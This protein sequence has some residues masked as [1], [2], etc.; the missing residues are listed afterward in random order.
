MDLYGQEPETKLLAGFLG[1]LDE[2]VVLDV[3]AEQGSFAQAM[4]DAGARHVHVVE[5][6]PQNLAALRD[7]FGTNA[8]VTVH[9]VAAGR[10]DG[11]LVLHVSVGPDGSPVPYGH[12]ILERPATTEIAWGDPIR[13]Q[14]RSIGSLV[15]DGL[16]PERVGIVKIDTEGNDLA[17]V[18]GLGDIVCD[19][20]V[21]EHWD[22]LPL[23]LGPCPWTLDEV[24]GAMRARGFEH[25]AFI[26]HRGEL[27]LLEWDVAELSAGEMGNLVFIHERAVARLLPSAIACA[28][29]LALRAYDVTRMYAQAA[30]ERLELIQ[31]LDAELRAR[32]AQA[33]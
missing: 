27:V 19:V 29:A 22:D 17:V 21:L 20:V 32:E 8:A 33:R 4:L 24:A 13:V 28:S 11:E 9:P 10:E 6:E 23:S 25:F 31:R 18:E 5:P 14:A 3:G 2:R 7:R 12:T 30:Q 16:I 26:A 15:R 1:A